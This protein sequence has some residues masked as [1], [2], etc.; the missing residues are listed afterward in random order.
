MKESQE[1]EGR[2][3][4]IMR[5]ERDYRAQNYEFH[6]ALIGARIDGRIVIVQLLY[7]HGGAIKH[8]MPK[9]MCVHL[10][11]LPSVYLYS[12]SPLSSVG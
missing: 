5:S 11:Q 2:D 9:V 6:N 10:G 1:G 12:S 7:R 4:V 8:A 3:S